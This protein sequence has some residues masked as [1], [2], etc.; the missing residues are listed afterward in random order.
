MKKIF[1]ALT[2]MVLL[3]GCSS[4]AYE[5]EPSLEP[6]FLTYDPTLEYCVSD[7]CSTD[8][9]VYEDKS[10]DKVTK[11][12]FITYDPTLE[13]CIS[14]GCLTDPAGPYVDDSDDKITKRAYIVV[15]EEL[16]YCT[17]DGCT[18]DTAMPGDH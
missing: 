9:T 2:M 5:G 3:A 12:L 13:Y 16:N 15:N 11:P 14:D 10:D 6:A 8:P 18:T 17:A 7:G 1:A 4:V